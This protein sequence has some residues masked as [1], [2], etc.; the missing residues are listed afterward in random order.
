[1]QENFKGHFEAAKITFDKTGGEEALE[2][3]TIKETNENF[4]KATRELWKEFAVSGVLQF[5][6]EQG[7]QVLRP[8]TD[9]D[10][11]SSLDLLKM[12]GI[13]VSNLEYVKPGAYKEGAINLDTGDKFGVEYN[14]DSYT[15]FFDHHA[16]EV[17]EVTST[18]EIVYQTMTKLGLLKKS[19]E[20]DRL[21]D[22]VT[23]IDNRKYPPEEFLKSGKTILGIQRDLNFERLLNYFK[24]HEFP[25]EELTLEDFE[26]YGLKES[27]LK[28]QKIV[29]ESMVLLQKMEKEGKVVDTKFGK[30]LINTNNE[31]KTGAS[32]AYVKFDGI[33]NITPE[34]SFA[35]TLKKHKFNEEELKQKLGDKF[36]GKIIRE[37]MWI[38]NDA[39]SLK[40]SLEEILDSVK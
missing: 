7:G 25:T 36:Q 8:F 38:Y 35:F 23:K 18:A 1:M 19:K 5:D 37:Q 24:D 3:K 17:K 2:G 28:Q 29:D 20:L 34:K 13:D 9:L 10:G 30:V 6:K 21:V 26:K 4:K 14:E 40:V 39:E 32:A 27:A 15:A 16:K 31:L 33:I 11:R 12:S 22:F